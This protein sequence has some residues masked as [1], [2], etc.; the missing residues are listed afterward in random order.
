LSSSAQQVREVFLVPQD[1][2]A[3]SEQLLA[4]VPVGLG[5]LRT[6]AEAFADNLQGVVRTLSI[7]FQ[8]TYSQVYS[9]HWQRAHIAARIR[10]GGA[11]DDAQQAETDRA[12]AK[13][14]FEE[15]LRGEGGKLLA[16]EVVDH[17]LQLKSE[18]ESLAAAR[19]LTRQGVVLTWSA[20]E[21]LARD[22]F[23]YF[24]NCKPRMS[25]ALLADQFN[26]KRFATDRVDWQTLATN[27]FDLSGKLGT[28][29]I[30]KADL[31][32]VPA[33]RAAYTALFPAAEQLRICLLD[34]R[35]WHLSQKRHLIVH[36]RGVADEAYIDATGSSLQIGDPL[37]VAPAEVEDAIE[38]AM[39]L[40]A[41][42]LA[43][44][45]NTA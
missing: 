9:L 30:S 11:P 35:L 19:E 39:A 21:V 41:E 32:N 44:I 23:V 2:H 27:G 45:A 24:L 6:I 34:E 26:K 3:S 12:S 14:K 43:Q 10:S 28:Y 36:R 4:R 33:I 18:R 8:Y 1:I 13:A 38:A 17:L 37:W 40:G 29:L 42:L 15:H 22:A 20:V 5:E 31:S 16:D 7:P 25:D